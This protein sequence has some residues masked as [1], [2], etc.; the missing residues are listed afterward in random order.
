MMY[1]VRHRLFSQKERSEATAM[2]IEIEE[3]PGLEPHANFELDW[4]RACTH[5]RPKCEQ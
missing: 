5:A 1:D 3:L 2:K 4:K